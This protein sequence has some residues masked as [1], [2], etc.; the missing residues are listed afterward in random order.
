MVEKFILDGSNS[1]SSILKE[2]STNISQQDLDTSKSQ[3]SANVSQTW[4]LMKENS[5][6]KRIQTPGIYRKVWTRDDFEIGKPLGRGKFGRV[7]LAREKKSK[8]IVA[9]KTMSIKQLSGCGVEHQLRREIEIQTRMQHSGIVRLFGF[10]WD[11]KTIYLILEYC[12]RGELYREL[13]KKKRIPEMRTADYIYQ[14]ADA[15]QYCHK[16]HVIHRDIKPENLLIGYNGELKL[17]DFGWSVHAPSSRR[18]TL[19]GTL[20][21]LAP[22]M[23]G[24]IPHSYQVDLWTV[25][26]L[27]YELLT[28]MAPFEHMSKQMTKRKIAEVDFSFP[29][30]VPADARDLISKLL[31][32]RPQERISLEEI[33]KHPWIVRNRRA[34]LAQQ[35]AAAAAAANAAH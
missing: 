24:E 9:L 7:Y 8:Y 18:E 14:L 33:M 19:C 6:L 32:K 26:V 23:V 25:G 35:Q 16:M 3:S 17:A 1:S 20:D 29:E 22:E 30:G 13:Q 34:K 28:G 2:T 11:E 31:R 10:F 4:R 15:L 12:P 27:A 5:L 21:Y